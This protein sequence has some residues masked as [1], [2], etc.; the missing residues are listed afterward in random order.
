MVTHAKQR[1]QNVAIQRHQGA[2]AVKLRR[3]LCLLWIK[4]GKNVVVLLL[5]HHDYSNPQLLDVVQTPDAD[6]A[7]LRAGN[8]RE[9][10]GGENTDDGYDHQQLDEREAHF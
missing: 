7:I 3:G 5:S 2:D 1:G 10:Q 8:G 9:Q 6:G 4:S